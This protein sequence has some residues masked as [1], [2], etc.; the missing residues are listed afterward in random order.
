M[1]KDDIFFNYWRKVAA[2]LPK[3]RLLLKYP[4]P[5]HPCWNYKYLICHINQNVFLTYFENDLD[6]LRAL[7]Y[8]KSSLNPTNHPPPPIPPPALLVFKMYMN[9]SIYFY[10]FTRMTSTR[11]DR[12]ATQTPTS[13]SS[14][15]ASCLPLHL[16]T[17]KKNGFPRSANT[18]H[19]RPSFW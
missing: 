9:I 17:S 4:H 15:S 3:Q 5:P 16:P 19:A 6:A 2:L 14:A 18:I 1:K 10:V 7:Y 13:S 8:P 12:S 11:F